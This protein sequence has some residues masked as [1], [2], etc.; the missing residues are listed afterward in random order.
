VNEPLP[1][2]EAA[3]V[4]GVSTRSLRRWISDG[5][6][7]A[8]AGG[9]GRGKRTL[10]DPAAVLAWRDGA[11]LDVEMRAFAAAIP[12][13]LADAVH[14]AFTLAEGPHKRLLAG[15]LVA[16]WYLASTALIDELRDRGI[17]VPEL[18]APPRK[19]D[20]LRAVFGRSGNVPRID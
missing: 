19:V 3:T 6:P 8:Q 2:A 12:D 4:L 1:I 14:E 20:M 5:A 15:A 9:R 16:T 13:L 11:R 10:V 18:A 17:D 7:V